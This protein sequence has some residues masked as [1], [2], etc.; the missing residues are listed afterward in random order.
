MFTTGFRKIAKD[1]TL[2]MRATP[3]KHG[4]RDGRKSYTLKREG[5]TWTCTC[6]DFI[7][8]HAGAGTE[9]KHIKAHKAGKKPWEMKKAS[10]VNID[11]AWEELSKTN[12]HAIQKETAFKWGAR[13][14]AAYRQYLKTK[15]PKWLFDGDEYYHE[16]IEH[17]ALVEHKEP[18]IL[19]K[20]KSVVLPLREKAH[21]EFGEE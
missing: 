9:C 11:K 4:G 3:A 5:K 2:K 12:I 14:G 20:I 15:D 19:R 8:R 17:A 6:P 13:G 18:A 16:S 7:Y 21:R 1:V 10:S